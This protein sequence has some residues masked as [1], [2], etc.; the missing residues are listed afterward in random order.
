MSERMRCDTLQNFCRI[1][2]ASSLT[3]LVEI[4]AAYLTE[5]SGRSTGFLARIP[6]D[7]AARSSDHGDARRPHRGSHTR[8]DGLPK[9]WY[10]LYVS[11]GTY[12]I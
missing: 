8:T 4:R 5:A 9:L 10:I 6:D 3:V 11:T 7:E 2:A 1:S 12:Q